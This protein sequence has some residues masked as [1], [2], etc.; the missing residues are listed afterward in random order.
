MKETGFSYWTS[1]NTDATNSSGFSARGAGMRY[2]Y[3]AQFGGIGQF[4]SFWS[5]TE[6]VT[7]PNQVWIVQ[8]ESGSTAAMESTYPKAGGLSVRCVKD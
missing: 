1:W 5:T 7:D 6:Y 3:N 8:M 4:G 2:D